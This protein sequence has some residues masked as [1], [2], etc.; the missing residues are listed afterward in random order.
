MKPS[1]RAQRQDARRWDPDGN[2]VSTLAPDD[3][4]GSSK[5]YMQFYCHCEPC[6][7]WARRYRLARY[8]VQLHNQ[9]IIESLSKKTGSSQQQARSVAQTN[10]KLPTK[11]PTPDRPTPAEVAPPQP[12]K[13]V[14]IDLS[15]VQIGA[16]NDEERKV[17]PVVPSVREQIKTVATFE[18]ISDAYFRPEWTAPLENGRERRAHGE[19]QIIVD[20]N[21]DAPVIWF[22]EREVATGKPEILQKVTNGIA[23]AKGGR[24][25]STGPTSVNSLL[26]LLR[27]GGCTIERAGSGHI[28]V[29]KNG[30]TLTLPSTASDWRSLRNTLAE[31]KRQGLL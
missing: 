28:K 27:K 12:P 2:L 20:P 11:L 25:G 24:G 16:K 13:P 15:K 1:V 23:K 18:A 6:N 14:E 30:R 22:G 7:K 9:R 26:E 17:F 3:A 10:G 31:A 19:M 29:A 4:H 5:G 8:E 21:G